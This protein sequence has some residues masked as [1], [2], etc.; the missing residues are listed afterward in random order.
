MELEKLES[1]LEGFDNHKLRKMKNIVL[2]AIITSALISCQNDKT[3]KST[4]VIINKTKTTEKSKFRYKDIL[5]DKNAN[6]TILPKSIKELFGVWNID[7]IADVG[8]TLQDEKL[9]QSQIGHELLI[10]ESQ[11][12]FYFLNDHLKINKPNY[13]LEKSDNVKGT[14]LWFGYRGSRK[15]ATWLKADKS[16]FFEIVN[17][18]ELAYYF[19]GRIYFFKRKV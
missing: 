7:S 2:F 14:T 15:F 16:H 4:T 10:S 5:I 12:S 18:H 17:E 13:S 6:D 1:L 11:L 19:D 8:G 3:K 9:I